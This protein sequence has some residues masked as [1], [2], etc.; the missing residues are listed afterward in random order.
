[1]LATGVKAEA[2][3]SAHL[4]PLS[5]GSLNAQGVDRGSTSDL[6][7]RLVD[8]RFNLHSFSYLEDH[9]ATISPR[10]EGDIENA[11]ASLRHFLGQLKE[12]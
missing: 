10:I 7:H 5:G 1:M 12:R 8:T 3:E 2:L 9:E 6:R 11:L 4:A